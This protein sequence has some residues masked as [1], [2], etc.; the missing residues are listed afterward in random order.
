MTCQVFLDPFK[1]H[2][3][4]RMELCLNENHRLTSGRTIR[5]C[6]SISG[7]WMATLSVHGI[8]NKEIGWSAQC[9]I[10]DLSINRPI[11]ELEPIMNLE[12]T[13]LPIAFSFEYVLNGVPTEKPVLFVAF[14]CG[15]QVDYKLPEASINLIKT[16]KIPTAHANGVNI[17]IEAEPGRIF[18]CGKLILESS[19]PIRYADSEISH[20]S[21]KFVIA[22]VDEHGGK[23]LVH[24]VEGNLTGECFFSTVSIGCNASLKFIVVDRT[25]NWISLIT[26]D[27]CVRVFGVTKKKFE[28]KSPKDTF[29]LSNDTHGSLKTCDKFTKPKVWH[30][31]YRLT[32]V[33]S[34][35]D[36][37]MC[38]VHMGS[39]VWAAV[40]G[41]GNHLVY[42][43]DLANVSII[44]SSRPEHGSS[45][46]LIGILDKPNLHS[47]HVRSNEVIH[48]SW[49]PFQSQLVS[50]LE[51]GSV[52]FWTPEYPTN[53]TALIVNLQAIDHNVYYEESETDFDLYK[54]VCG[55]NG[56]KYSNPILVNNPEKEFESI[57]PFYVS[58]DTFL[59][60]PRISSDLLLFR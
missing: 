5:V 15:L 29:H 60:D 9:H 8:Y 11:I 21:G 2:W 12:L 14:S 39:V 7:T 35:V 24:I 4:C 20:E 59:G 27:R 53:W 38:G 58:N 19:T 13:T 31:M 46:P 32:E 52:V 10:W 51:D 18:V 48:L 57:D 34:R 28:E 1:M 3:P 25:L 30:L 26:K 43:W 50:I 41:T 47:S 49:N 17:L 40:Q 36:W 44:D 45:L 42:L 6:H 16:S 37:S 55:E 56:E 22:Y 54:V 33:V 23:G